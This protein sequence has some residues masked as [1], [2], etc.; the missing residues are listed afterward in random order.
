[1]AQRLPKGRG[2]TLIPGIDIHMDQSGI[3]ISVYQ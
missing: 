2:I 3:L 1:M